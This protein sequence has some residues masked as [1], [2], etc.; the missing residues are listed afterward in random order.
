ME[1]EKELEKSQAATLL[2]Q[3][4]QALESDTPEPIQLDDLTISLS[5]QVEILLEYEH[6]DGETE[7]ELEFK[8][9][10]PERKQRPGKFELYQ[11]ASDRL[12]FGQIS[13]LIQ[14]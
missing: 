14:A 6:E 4:A 9:S 12:L 8:W 2:K 3:I 5:P 10:E 13:R 11:S 1:L 7:L